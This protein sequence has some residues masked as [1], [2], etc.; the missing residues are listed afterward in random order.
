MPVTDSTIKLSLSVT[1]K[2]QDS[3]I[4]DKD[5]ALSKELS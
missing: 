3:Q 2:N 4:I 1:S 5:A